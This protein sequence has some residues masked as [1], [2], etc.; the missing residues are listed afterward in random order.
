MNNDAEDFSKTTPGFHK[1]FKFENFT[2]DER[3][4]LNKLKKEWY[5]TNSGDQFVIGF[6]QYRYFLMKPTTL[7]SEMFNIERELVCI[8]SPYETF[9]PRT[10]DAFDY[11]TSKIQKL[12]IENVCRILISMD[13]NIVEKIGSLLKS[14]PEQPIVVPFS[15]EE[16]SG[17]FDDFFIR[18]R[19]RTHFYTRDLF[20]FQSPLKKD[21]YFFGRSELI[22]GIINRHKSGEHNA[23][24]GLRKSGKTSV[25]YGIERSMA[26]QGGNTVFIDCES[27]SIHKL[28]WNELLRY[29]VEVYLR[30]T[31]QTSI[32]TSENHKYD[33]KRAAA[34]F[35]QD[36][37]KIYS[38]FMKPTLIIFDEIERISPRT[39]SSTH[40]K[41]E[42]D[43]VL[44]W[45]SMRYFYQKHHEVFTYMLVGTN[46]YCVETPTFGDHDNPL[47]SSMPF[48]YV[49]NFD[50][51]KSREMVRKL[52]RYMG[53]KFDELIYSKL[54]ED[55]G[56]HPFLIRQMCSL[57]HN[58][59]P[60]D[61]PL[62]VD[63]ALY[64][65]VKKYFLENSKNYVE[66]IVQVL[67]QWY[68]NEYEMLI[69]LAI[70][71]IELF[72]DFTKEHNYESNHLVG[73]GLI[74][75]S[76]HGYSFNIDCV[77][78]YLLDL[79]KYNKKTMTP[80]QQALEVFARRSTLEKKLRK[81]IKNQLKA[82]YGSRNGR[83]KVI[84]SLPENRRE[85]ISNANFDDLLNSDNSP[86]FF[87]ELINIIEREWE[88]FKN[89][90]EE[91]KRSVIFW[92]QEINKF[93]ADAHSNNLNQDDFDELR[94]FFS[95]IE[96][97]I[98]DF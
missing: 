76:K 27:P 84:S 24:F 54:T 97:K 19:F 83:E 2:I 18:N 51:N 17:Q 79:N 31:N 45:Q 56:G 41:S 93:R 71:D 88:L 77:R 29:V 98:I 78:E 46:P 95:K 30:S 37:L 43:F 81:I 35:E 26:S 57:I 1:L 74:N 55:F 21:L 89:I 94:V 25:V 75:R 38:S 53:I 50:V 66:M 42:D 52:G 10:L 44:F 80:E 64:E 11:V 15:Y 12:R 85:K 92:L 6:S 34:T 23:L 67:Q 16:L 14:D 39:G 13:K 48:Q 62:S 68:P 73:Y 69:L 91:E 82:V 5:L 28:R 3:A 86:L 8:F 32:K 60:G 4:I 59:H 65:K 58:Q 9:E 49:P 36:M 63:K 90:F 47:F 7:F 72:S 61:R 70:G 20:S 87:L 22:Q 40:W 33:E 96:K